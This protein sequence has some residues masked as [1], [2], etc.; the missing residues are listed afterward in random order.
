MSETTLRLKTV[1]N[2]KRMFNNLE[3][4]LK[5]FEEGEQP[6]NKLPKAVLKPFVSWEK[7]LL[8]ITLLEC[9]FPLISFVAIGGS[10]IDN[11][12]SAL[13]KLIKSNSGLCL[14]ILNDSR[15]DGLWFR[16]WLED[17][18]FEYVTDSGYDY[19]DELR[20]G[21]F[22]EQDCFEVAEGIARK[23]YAEEL[24][25]LKLKAP[26]REYQSNRLSICVKSSF[27]FKE[28]HLNKMKD[29]MRAKGWSLHFTKT[30]PSIS[31]TEEDHY[32]PAVDYN[33]VGDSWFGCIATKNTELDL[34]KIQ[35]GI[36]YIEAYN[37][38][39]IITFCIEQDFYMQKP[40]MKD[41]DVKKAFKGCSWFIAFQLK[42]GQDDP[43]AQ[44]LLS[45]LVQ[46]TAMD[47]GSKVIEDDDNDICYLA[48]V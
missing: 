39:R 33:E 40:N 25:I 21:V 9:E 23:V 11:T 34:E 30:Q 35:R 14:A 37:S 5:S 44:K 7:E 20:N 47:I 8:S 26:F 36:D 22:E 6:D 19:D 1:I 17:F 18:S 38:N 29:N 32:I 42:D 48:P 4:L 46:L 43:D 2:N 24:E 12:S 28:K 31:H 16:A 15:S 10:P 41:S 45:S 27:N 3:K 13:W